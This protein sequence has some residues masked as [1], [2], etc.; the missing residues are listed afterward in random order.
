MPKKKVVKTPAPEVV[1]APEV[2]VEE[3]APKS[4]PSKE[5]VFCKVM[6]RELT[7]EG[8]RTGGVASKEFDNVKDAEAFAVE[9]KGKLVV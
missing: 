3:E 9:V 1:E 6:Y 2:V 4:K 8:T 5:L 7:P